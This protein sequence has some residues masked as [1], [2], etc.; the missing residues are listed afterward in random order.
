MPGMNIDIG[1]DGTWPGNQVAAVGTPTDLPAADF[2]HSTFADS[3]VPVVLFLAIALTFCA[4]Y[5]FAHRSRNA[6]LQ[7]VRTAMEHGQPLGPDLLEQL[8]EPGRPRQRDLRR[9]VIGIGLG[10][11]LAGVGLVLG[12]PDTVRRM[13]AVSLVPL[14]LGLAY[15]V[16]WHLDARNR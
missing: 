12:E 15:L 3:I 2:P 5:Y 7:T 6:L 8:G 9:G 11:G 1:G 14:L 16:L 10:I 4:K 13:L